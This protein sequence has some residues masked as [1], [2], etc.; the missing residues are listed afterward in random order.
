MR[1]MKVRF[2][3]YIVDQKIMD[4]LLNSQAD[5]SRNMSRI[6]WLEKSNL[7]RTNCFIQFYKYKKKQ[8]KLK[9]YKTNKHYI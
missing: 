2:L 1:L 7:L 5:Y 8:L 9:L 6:W 4:Q 3:Q